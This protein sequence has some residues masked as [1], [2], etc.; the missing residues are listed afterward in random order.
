MIEDKLGLIAAWG[1]IAFLI[2]RYYVIKHLPNRLE[3]G[4]NLIGK[5]RYRVDKLLGIKG[6]P[7][8]VEVKYLGAETRPARGSR[9]RAFFTA[10]TFG[11][12][13]SLLV[14][15]LEGHD[16]CHR[17]LVRYENGEIKT[18]LCREDDPRYAELMSYVRWEDL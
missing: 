11:L 2:I 7:E 14:A 10:I 18:V 15:S 9:G 6:L 4:Y 13:E 17:F 3:G 8:I 1:L 16:T 5:I 12:L